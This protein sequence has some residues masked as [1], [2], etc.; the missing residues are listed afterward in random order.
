MFHIFLP[1][2]SFVF[3]KNLETGGGGGDKRG[4]PCL[5]PSESH[6][7]EFSFWCATA[8]A[9]ADAS[10]FPNLSNEHEA[11]APEVACH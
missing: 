5:P 9:T 7:L 2:Y 6:A 10:Q 1:L 3:P 8:H 4:F 11:A